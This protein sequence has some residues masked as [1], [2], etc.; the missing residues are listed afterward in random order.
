[1]TSLMS[2]AIAFGMVEVSSPPVSLPLSLVD[3]DLVIARLT[4]D[5]IKPTSAFVSP[6]FAFMKTTF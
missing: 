5:S 3:T 2:V 6:S 4:F 1:M